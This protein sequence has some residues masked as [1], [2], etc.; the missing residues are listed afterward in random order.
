MTVVLKVSAKTKISTGVDESEM[1]GIPFK[2]FPLKIAEKSAISFFTMTTVSG[3]GANPCGTVIRSP[4]HRPSSW[5]E[6]MNKL[7]RSIGGFSDVTI[8]R[9][10]TR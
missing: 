8:R 9:L 10:L 1:G 7:P 3:P 4:L 6:M 5:Y 2:L